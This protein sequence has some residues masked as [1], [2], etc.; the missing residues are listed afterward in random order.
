MNMRHQQPAG[1]RAA[2]LTPLHVLHL[3]ALLA[4]QHH[5]LASQQVGPGTG[6]LTKHLLQRGARVTAVEKDDTLYGRL[7]EQY[8]DVSVEWYM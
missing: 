3:L 8:K 6:N 1:G 2:K 4:R 5:S 7:V